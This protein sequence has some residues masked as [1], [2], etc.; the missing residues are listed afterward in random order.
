MKNRVSFCVQL[1]EKSCLLYEKK[2][3]FLLV[4]NFIEK[5]IFD[6]QSDYFDAGASG[7]DSA[8]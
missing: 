6:D 3:L 7:G 5:D 4:L 8:A 1:G 2:L